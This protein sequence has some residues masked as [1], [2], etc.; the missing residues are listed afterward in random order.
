M[1][2]NK[3]QQ[4]IKLSEVLIMKFDLAPEVEVYMDSEGVSL[5]RATKALEM[6]PEEAASVELE[7][8]DRDDLSNCRTKR[9][10]RQHLFHII[11][12]AKEN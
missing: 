9:I 1:E 12:F 11:N 7:I 2:S 8:V 5:E 3:T 10:V 6:Y 4:L